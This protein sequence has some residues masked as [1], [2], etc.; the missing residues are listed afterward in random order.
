MGKIKFQSFM[1]SWLPGIRKKKALC[2]N[3]KLQW[4]GTFFGFIGF[5]GFLVFL[6]FLVL[7]VVFVLFVLFVLL[8]YW[9]YLGGVEKVFKQISLCEKG[10]K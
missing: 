3:G 9:F 6:V 2:G 7:L 1:A 4:I 5:T 10:I 8:V